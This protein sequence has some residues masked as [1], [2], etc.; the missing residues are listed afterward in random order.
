MTAVSGYFADFQ[1][2]NLSGRYGILNYSQITS[3]PDAK[4][5]NSDD[6]S[7]DLASIADRPG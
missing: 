6:Y 5:F 1:K 4:S 3:S 2:N 7:E